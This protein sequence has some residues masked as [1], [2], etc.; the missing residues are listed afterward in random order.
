LLLD[1]PQ[2]VQLPVELQH[3]GCNIPLRFHCAFSRSRQYSR[4][5]TG[6]FHFNHT[7]ANPC[8]SADITTKLRHIHS[9]SPLTRVISQSL[10]PLQHPQAC[11]TCYKPL[12]VA[13]SQ[14]KKKPTP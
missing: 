8:R 10:T 13:A 3:R 7:E 2:T 11:T 9:C 6:R 5:K 4:D 12:A 1:S 14:A